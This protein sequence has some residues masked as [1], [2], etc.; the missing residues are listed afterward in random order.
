MLKTSSNVWIIL[1]FVKSFV[2]CILCKAIY[3]CQLFVFSLHFFSSFKISEFILLFEIKSFPDSTFFLKI[4]L[5]DGLF[6]YLT[7]SKRCYIIFFFPDDNVDIFA[8][9]RLITYYVFSSLI[10]SS[11]FMSIFYFLSKKLRLKRKGFKSSI[12]FKSSIID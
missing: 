6:Y 12:W 2:F 7:L 10:F 5:Q 8:V 3:F 4:H 11:I 1:N 9:S